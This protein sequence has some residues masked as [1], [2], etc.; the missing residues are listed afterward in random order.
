MTPADADSPDSIRPDASAPEAIDTE[1]GRAALARF[2]VVLYQ[3]QDLVNIALVVRAMKNMGLTRL[4]LVSPA[5]YNAYRV[6]GIA[7]DTH[8]IVNAV[9]LFDEF[10]QAVADVVRVVAMTARRR[11]S[12]QVWREPHSA[13]EKL[14]AGSAEGDIALVFGREDRGLPNEI[15]DR[16]HE[17]VCI[18]TNPEHPSLNLGQAAMVVLYEVRQAVRRSFDLDER[19]LSG[20][21]RDQAP[22]ATAAELEEFFG[23]WEQAM[24]ALGMFRG[25]EPITKMRSYRRILKR[26]EPD[27]RELR[28]FEATAWRIVNFATRIEAR[29][30]DQIAK[31]A[32]KH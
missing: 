27:R 2:V 32:R 23:V 19:D 13:A 1:A 24:S 20:K 9:E 14:V 29:I 8:E 26:S 15:L 17:A 22:P 31:E 28:L 12:R 4:R 11:A 5:V 10:D 3:P 30:R 16:C 18:P 21:I 6:T 25:V 7:H